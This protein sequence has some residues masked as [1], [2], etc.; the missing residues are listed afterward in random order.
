MT[1]H[2]IP[3]C[4]PWTFFFFRLIQYLFVF[5]LSNPEPTP[6]PRLPGEL[7]EREHTGQTQEKT[8][9]GGNSSFI[10]WRRWTRPPSGKRAPWPLRGP[11][12]W[13]S[14]VELLFQRRVRGITV[15]KLPNTVPLPAL[16]PATPAVAAPAPGNLAAVS[17]SFE[18]ALVWKLG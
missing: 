14:I 2:A 3:H 5:L 8:M 11:S 7:Q 6:F 15:M 1:F 18:M 4:S 12:P 17:K 10:S 16:E 9:G 13:H